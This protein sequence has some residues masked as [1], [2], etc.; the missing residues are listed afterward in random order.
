MIQAIQTIP[1]SERYP[2]AHTFRI[3][4]LTDITP[5]PYKTIEIG[6]LGAR[7]LSAAENLQREDLTVFETL[8]PLWKSSMRNL[9]MT[10]IQRRLTCF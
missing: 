9:L 2:E 4:P 8:K 5:S 10:K 7:R 6:D 3:I 1:D